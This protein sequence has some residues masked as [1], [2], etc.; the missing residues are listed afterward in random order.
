MELQTG[1]TVD[2]IHAHSKKVRMM[3]ISCLGFIV[4]GV[5][6]LGSQ[7]WMNSSSSEFLE[8]VLADSSE[9]LSPQYK[10]KTDDGQDF[11]IT[12]K[13]AKELDDG[14]VFLSSPVAN[15]FKGG[16][17]SEFILDSVSGVYDG[18][19][20]TLTLKDNVALDDGDGNSFRA[21]EIMLDL[22]K[23]II[24]SDNK[25]DLSGKMGKITSDKGMEIKNDGDIIIFKGKSKM[26]INNVTK[27]IE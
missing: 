27:V 2:N 3:Y 16:E 17:F 25:I 13:K 11:S 15:L 7:L 5:L 8:G 23:N 14:T 20:K 21:S 24:Y 19:E 22:E 6:I 1:I 10:G 18:K 12:S 26:I 9:M 4:I